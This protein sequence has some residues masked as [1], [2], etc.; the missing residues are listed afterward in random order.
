MITPGLPI[1]TSHA[2]GPNSPD[3]EEYQLAHL[4]RICTQRG[5]WVEIK[6]REGVAFATVENYDGDFYDSGEHPTE[7]EALFVAMVA[8][9]GGKDK[10]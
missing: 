5:W 9:E 1:K 3:T 10:G 4:K 8:A 2:F 6:L 7:L